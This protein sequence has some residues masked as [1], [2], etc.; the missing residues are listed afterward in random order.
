MATI[1]SIGPPAGGVVEILHTPVPIDLPPSALLMN[2]GPAGRASTT[3][4]DVVSAT[5]RSTDM[6]NGD[7][8]NPLASNIINLKL[9]YG[10]DSDGDGVMD[11]WV[12]AEEAGTWNPVALL[13]APRGTL[14]RIMALR[15]G[16]IARSDAFDQHLVRAF[17]WVLFDCGATDK[18]ACPGR[19]EGTIAGSAR[20]GY[21]YRTYETVVPLRNSIWNRGA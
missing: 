21:R 10:I 8:P 11:D 15:I 4:Y 20:G 2:L 12:S 1:T 14:D 16:V 7:A 3:R 5:L 9:Q 19:L 18:A 17:R 13:A 6:T